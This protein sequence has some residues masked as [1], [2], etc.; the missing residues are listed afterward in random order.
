MT[1]AWDIYWQSNT[2]ANSFLCNYNETGGPYGLVNKLWHTFFES[3]TSTN[4]VLDLGCGNGALSEFASNV[5][6]SELFPHFY[7]IDAARVNKLVR[8]KRVSYL[9]DDMQSLSLGDASVSHVISMFGL[10]YSSVHKSIPEFLRVLKKQGVWHC[11]CHHKDSVITQQSQ[12]TMAVI[13]LLMQD[14]QFVLLEKFKNT[15]KKQLQDHLLKCLQKHLQSVKLHEQED[16]KLI[17]QTVFTILKSNIDSKQCIRALGK[18]QQ[19]LIMNKDRLLQQVASANQADL[20]DEI[21][22]QLDV[23]QWQVTPLLYEAKPIGWLFVGIK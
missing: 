3:L 2:T 6:S 16:V 5:L 20:I 8:H 14:E 18:F 7:N 10:E 11:V 21:M 15:P 22:H 13:D 17:G 9:Q 23:S 12:I 1:K 4:S 19:H